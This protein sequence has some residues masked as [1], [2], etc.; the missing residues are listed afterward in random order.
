MTTAGLSAGCSLAEKDSLPLQWKTLTLVRGHFWHCIKSSIWVGRWCTTSWEEM[1][2]GIAHFW[3]K[4][5]RGFN[6]KVPWCRLATAEALQG[7]RRSIY[8]LTCARALTARAPPHCHTK[9][10]RFASELITF[11]TA[12]PGRLTGLI[13]EMGT[14]KSPMIPMSNCS[15]G[16][17][18]RSGGVTLPKWNSSTA[19]DCT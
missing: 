5:I 4:F 17:F 9:P 18:L 6:T 11:P 19:L 16:K 15:Y 7:S 1:I 3:H 10:D 14:F 2:S 12:T 8:W 13:N